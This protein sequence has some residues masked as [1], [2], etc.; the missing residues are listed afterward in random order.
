ML[1]IPFLFGLGFCG[2]GQ[3]VELAP[4]VRAWLNAQTNIQTWAADVTQTRTLKTLS[5]P[6]MSKGQV[7]FSAPKL[8][9]WEIGQPTETV[10][11]RQADQMLVIYPRLKRVER[12]AL[13][14]S[15][16]GPWRE[17]LA[18][19]EAGFPRSVAELQS[20]FNV[21]TQKPFNGLFELTLEPKSAAARRMIP[22]IKILFSR[23]DHVLRATELKFSDGSIMRNEFS[24]ARL[25]PELDESLF[26]PQPGEGFKTVEPLKK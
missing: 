22:Q 26:D 10:A 3:A 19:L 16:T 18:L 4:E 12:Y 2:I 7:W 11:V 17:T 8:F 20:R 9:R 1:W 5:H 21:V 6:L 14:A 13:D 15:A 24:N 23:Q 25:N